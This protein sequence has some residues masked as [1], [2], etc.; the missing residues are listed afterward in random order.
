MQHEVEAPSVQRVAEAM[1]RLALSAAVRDEAAFE[2]TYPL[3]DEDLETV[4][5][6]YEAFGELPPKGYLARVLWWVR[7]GGG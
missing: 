5:A 2:H 6:F 3:R 7:G 1:E 4:E